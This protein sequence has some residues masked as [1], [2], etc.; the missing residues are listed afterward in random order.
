ME[1][2][3]AAEAAVRQAKAEGLTLQQSD[4]SVTGYRGVRKDDRPG[5][6]INPFTAAVRR[7]GKSVYLGCFTTA[8]EAALAVARADARTHPPS[9]APRP[10]AAK[11]AAP[12]PQPPHAEAEEEIG[13]ADA[14]EAAERQAEA[15]GLTMQ[16]SDNAAGYRGVYYID[17]SKALAKPFFATVW[18][19][20][21]Q[22]HL[23]NFATA[24]EA[25]LTYARTPE[26]QADVASPKPAPLTA[27]EAVSQA[28]AEGLKLER[29]NRTA[30]Y[31]G[32]CYIVH[33]SRYK[34]QMTRAGK[35][36]NLGSFATAE[37]A[38][39]ASREQTRAPTRLPPRLPPRS[40]PRRR[41]SRRPQSSLATARPLVPCSPT[42]TQKMASMSR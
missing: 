36:V 38:A 5:H 6:E 9:A 20:S 16:P 14:A 18:R 26:A 33:N 17:R 2:T 3:D 23:G 29:S 41:R 32:V 8:E 42:P 39:L 27:V 40:A 34:A 25:A 7:D 12:P 22:V 35:K 15:E 37:E 31:R 28:A 24:E 21:K 30:G 11:R 4:N 10:S 19:A 13:Q 1:R